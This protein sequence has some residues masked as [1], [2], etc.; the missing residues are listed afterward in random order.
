MGQEPPHLCCIM[1]VCVGV[2]RAAQ[3]SPLLQV[4]DALLEEELG[5]RIQLGVLQLQRSHGNP[6]QVL[7]QHAVPV[8]VR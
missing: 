2:Y 7:Q 5:C 1:C 3:Q 4:C 8:H 6:K